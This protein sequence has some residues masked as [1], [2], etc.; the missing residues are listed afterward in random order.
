MTVAARVLSPVDRLAEAFLDRLV[1]LSPLLATEIGVPGHDADLDD[2]S[3]AGLEARADLARATLAE[4]G[5]LERAEGETWDEVDRVTADCLRDRLGSALELHDA[6]E[7]YRE[8]NNL[9]SAQHAVEDVFAL[10]PQE[11]AQDWAL[12]AERLAAVP[13][14]LAQHA[15]T[16]RAGARRGLTPARH[17]VEVAAQ[18]A[19]KQAGE[20]SVFAGLARQAEEAEWGPSRPDLVARVERG[21]RLAEAAYGDLAQFL[22]DEL[23]PVT[24]DRDGVGEERYARFSRAFLGATVD[25]RET[26]AWGQEELARIVAEQEAIAQAALGRGATVAA[27]MAG[28]NADPAL[29]LFGADAFR[30]WLQ[31]TADEAMAFLQGRHFD[32]PE[33]MET[34]EACLAPTHNGGVYYTAPSADFAR[35][36]R[37]WWSVPE[38]VDEFALWRERTTVYHEGVPGHH[39]QC[40]Q[41]VYQAPSL[42]RWRALDCGTSGHGEGWALYAERFM[43]EQ[44]FL[45]TP[46]DRMG[47]L[48][49]QRLRAARVVLDIGVHLELPFPGRTGELWNRDNAW[50]FLRANCDWDEP[51]LRFEWNRYLGWPGQAPSY[52][53]GQR[54]WE[55]LRDEALARGLALKDFHT[56]ALALGGVGLDTLRAALA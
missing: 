34:L 25:L 20:R 48:D 49:G 43:D 18:D 36:G 4:L 31:E 23:R 55:Q 21:A 52:K 53:I 7:G 1:Q 50:E 42:N 40:G 14:A 9:T 8:L 45:R 5:E 38:G 39:L 19:S 33:P 17:Q 27:A 26:Y 2:L 29:R 24:A 6:G 3:P 46:A 41:A 44:G 22:D 56:R 51:G 16:L 54:I 30:D 28:F 35:P 15:E 13:R 12:I 32:I 10:M 11:T 37:M 47:M